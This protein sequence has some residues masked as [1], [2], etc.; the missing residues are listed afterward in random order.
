MWS[1]IDQQ[2]PTIPTTRVW[3]FFFF[4]FFFNRGNV[5]LFWQRST[6]YTQHNLATCNYHIPKNDGKVKRGRGFRRGENA[7]AC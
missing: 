5:L 4:F 7:K 2:I 1:D 6:R 3:V